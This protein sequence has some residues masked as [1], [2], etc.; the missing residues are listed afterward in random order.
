MLFMRMQ[1][2]QGLI[3]TSRLIGSDGRHVKYLRSPS[4]LCVGSLIRRELEY[5]SMCV[6]CVKGSFC[7][8]FTFCL[9]SYS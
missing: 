7:F 6:S 3:A 5:I 9:L 4:T 1:Q 8:R 2:Q